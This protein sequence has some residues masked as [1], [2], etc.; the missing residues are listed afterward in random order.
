[1]RCG[2]Q[3]MK[4]LIACQA[5]WAPFLILRRLTTTHCMSAFLSSI[6][7]FKAL[8]NHSLHVRLLELHSSF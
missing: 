2:A 3:L 1:M 4:P 6:P 5:S 8:Y 7:H